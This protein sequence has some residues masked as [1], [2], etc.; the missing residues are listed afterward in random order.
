MFS[1][2]INNEF[3]DRSLIKILI[4]KIIKNIYKLLIDKHNVINNMVTNLEG[5]CIREWNVS[6]KIFF[7]LTNSYYSLF[8]FQV[9]LFFIEGMSVT[10]VT[11]LS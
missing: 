2:H 11:V 1:I 4:S 10:Q 6:Y 7:H 3:K 9:F 5:K 8:I